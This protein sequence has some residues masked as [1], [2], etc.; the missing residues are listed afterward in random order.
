MHL[1]SKKEGNKDYS[2]PSSSPTVI[3]LGRLEKLSVWKPSH[4][5]VCR[6]VSSKLLCV[7]VPVVYW[8][9]DDLQVRLIVGLSEP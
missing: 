3:L 7:P 5:V 9:P 2:A 1:P 6:T 4:P 8:V